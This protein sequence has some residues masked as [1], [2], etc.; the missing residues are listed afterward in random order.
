MHGSWTMRNLTDFQE[1]REQPILQM[2]DM[3]FRK[4]FLHYIEQYA[5]IFESKSKLVSIP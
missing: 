3:R 5:I 1:K 2:L 4:D